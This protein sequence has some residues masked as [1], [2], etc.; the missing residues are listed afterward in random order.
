MTCKVVLV[1]G[2]CC[3]IISHSC[4][5]YYCFLL[6][7]AYSYSITPY[8]NNILFM[9]P[10]LWFPASQLCP[11]SA[12]K[13]S[14]KSSGALGLGSLLTFFFVGSDKNNYIHIAKCLFPCSG[15]VNVPFPFDILKIAIRGTTNMS[16]FTFLCPFLNQCL[17]KELIIEFFPV[18]TKLNGTLIISSGPNFG[19]T[20]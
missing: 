1:H 15:L 19:C 11:H 16:S 4:C 14:G 5:Y 12:W 6:H 3:L 7:L 17:K 8:S 2:M 10:A 9:V 13:L 18:P 20:L